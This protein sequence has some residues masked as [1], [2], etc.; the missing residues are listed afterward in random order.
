MGL[1]AEHRLVIEESIGRI[2]ERIEVVHHINHDKTDN[3]LEN[4]QLFSSPGEH[5]VKGHPEL[6][7]RYRN[8]FKG[9]H[10]SP[11]TEFKKGL[12]PWNKGL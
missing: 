9:K 6:I 2:L 12:T 11:D 3:R 7:E 4:L 8:E 5:I 10:H 1:M